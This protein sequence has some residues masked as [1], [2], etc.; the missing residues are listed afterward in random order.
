[1][2][3]YPP[4]KFVTFHGIFYMSL[5]YIISVVTN[6]DTDFSECGLMSDKFSVSNLRRPILKLDW[7]FQCWREHRLVPHEPFR[8][9][10]FTGLVI[11]AT[12][13]PLGK[14][15]GVP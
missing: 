2:F 13:V 11:C 6:T 4:L 14:W 12:N 3:T 1:M 8:L 9:L 7:L 5:G 15:L 10:P